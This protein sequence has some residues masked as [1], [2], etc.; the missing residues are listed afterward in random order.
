MFFVVSQKKNEFLCLSII[1]SGSIIEVVVFWCAVV[2]AGQAS[3]FPDAIAASVVTLLN[4]LLLP[5]WIVLNIIWFYHS[6][7]DKTAEVPIIVL[8]VVS[9]QLAFYALIFF[10]FSCLPL[11]SITKIGVNPAGVIYVR[12]PDRSSPITPSLIRCGVL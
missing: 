11:P 7:S 12:P 1:I 5:M 8:P 3:V 10:I 2:A 9:A 6:R 4:T